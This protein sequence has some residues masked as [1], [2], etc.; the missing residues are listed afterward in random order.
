MLEINLDS[1]L[2]EAHQVFNGP[3]FGERL[4]EVMKYIEDRKPTLRHSYI[5]Y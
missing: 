4:A 3:I 5:T 1:A 2:V